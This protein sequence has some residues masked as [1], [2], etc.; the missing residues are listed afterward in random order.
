MNSL[1]RQ[2]TV[3]NWGTLLLPINKD[4]SIDWVR[5]GEEIDVRI[6]V[7][8]NGIYSNGTAGE[9]QNYIFHRII[10]YKYINRKRLI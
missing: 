8:V 3:G 10:A 5:L 1:N 2:N 7:R 9:F 6:E 4:D